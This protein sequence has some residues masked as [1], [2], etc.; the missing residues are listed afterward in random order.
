MSFFFANPWGLLALG[1]IPA[2]VLIHFLQ[3]QSRRVR[4][5]TLFLLEHARPTSEEGFRIE[6][7]QNSLPFWMQILAACA[8]AW[9]LADPR[10][11]HAEPRQTVAVVLDSSASMQAFR[12]DTLAALAA[13]LRAWEAAAD[14]TDWH[15]LET[16]P[17]RPPLYAGRSLTE[18][19]AAAEARWQ[20]VLGD[21]AF[22]DSLVA[23]RALVPAGAGGVVLVSDRDVDVPADVAVLSVATPIDNVG[24]SGV[25]VDQAE[26]V[27]TWRVLITNHS[28][29]PQSRNLTLRAAGTAGLADGEP[30]APPQPIEL[31]AGQSRSFSAAWPADDPDRL[32]LTLSEDA[33]PL[34][35]SL[36]LVKPVLRQV[37]LANRLSGPVGDLLG[38]M[39][40][41]AGG[42]VV[43]DDTA[44]ADLV[45][46]QLGSEPATDAI[47][48]ATGTADVARAD[49]DPSADGAIE[50]PPAKP[51][52]DPA[53]VAA[54][55]HPLV[56]D[57]S[58]G[59]LLSGPA[60]GMPLSAADTPL[61]WKD[62]RPLAFL[63]TTPRA[64]GRRSRSLVL[65]WDLAGSTA[66]RT[67]AVVVMLARFVEQV[68][69]Q[70]PS[71]WAANV[72]TGQAITLP[73]RRQTRAPEMPGFFEVP[74]AA[75]PMASTT[76]SGDG[77]AAPR[78]MLTA[79]AHFADARECDLR[80]ASPQD[81]L[82]A[83]RMERIVK[84]SV[85]DPW[86]PLWVAVAAA[87]LLVAWSWRRR[88]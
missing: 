86:A 50:A 80:G 2:I 41:A 85:E 33:F 39:L 36:P 19:L 3:E 52:L 32:V 28:D 12:E 67:A 21:H 16:G 81:T 65:N 79:A 74:L 20:P 17:R 18:L 15:L 7:F 64:D 49:D 53:W 87:A 82:D 76:P 40:A 11:V 77:D 35:D 10:W 84:R 44:Q 24:F 48:V 75:P 72:E 8:L 46:D 55:D 57:L 54:E 5:S 51:A 63:R 43:V 83:I 58:W 34:D 13:R 30:L 29:V 6:R 73:G 70:L 61:L 71:S 37:R 47:L 26:G 9:L 59:S 88:S 23:A 1:A 4:T 42:V 31:A 78:P 68:R 25:G 27:A 38:K 22:S 45:I 56:R 14:R 69:E 66:D 60:G 62:G